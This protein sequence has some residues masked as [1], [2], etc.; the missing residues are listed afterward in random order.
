M[1]QPTRQGVLATMSIDN[2]YKIPVDASANVHSVSGVGEQYLDLVSTGNLG[3]DLSPGQTITKVMVPGRWPT[4]GA[5]TAGWRCCPRHKIASL[6]D[7]TAQAVGGLG[8]TLQRLVDSTQALVGDFKTNITDVN[9]IIANSAPIL[10]SQVNSSDSI[11][12]WARNLNSLAA[13]TADKGPDTEKRPVQRG[14]DPRPDHRGIQRRAR[15]PAADAGESGDLV[16]PAQALPQQRRGAARGISA[17]HRHRAKRLHDL[18]RLFG[19]DLAF[20]INPTPPCL[21]GFVSASEWRSPPTPIQR[22]CHP[23]RTARFPRTPRAWCGAPGTTPAPMFPASAPRHR[24]S[25]AATSP[26]F[27]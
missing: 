17:A 1:S 16:R 6:L 4:L 5:P 25:A 14:T 3:K 18:P 15:V 2:R 19:L 27:R 21:T 9:D 22:R 23:G 10:D 11:E 8:P 13:Q 7:E 20:A 24:E 26:T 12:R